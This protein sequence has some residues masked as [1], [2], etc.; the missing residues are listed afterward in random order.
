MFNVWKVAILVIAMYT[1]VMPTEVLEISIVS[2]S[3]LPYCV[4]F[5][6]TIEIRFSYSSLSR[7]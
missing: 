2:L 1:R 4:V 7:N 5:H 3:F 6:Q